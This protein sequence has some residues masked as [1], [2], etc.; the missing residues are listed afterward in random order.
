MYNKDT[1]SPDTQN[2]L[3]RIIIKYIVVTTNRHKLGKSPRIRINISAVYICIGIAVLLQNIF[4]RIITAVTVTDY[5]YL[6]FYH[7]YYHTKKCRHLEVF[8]L[9]TLE[10]YLIIRQSIHRYH[11]LLLILR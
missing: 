4:Q 9:N 11:I 1:M 8:F 6:H 5:Y 2:L 3:I 7:R 10:L